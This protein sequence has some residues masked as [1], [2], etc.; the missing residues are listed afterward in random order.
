[1]KNLALLYIG[2]LTPD[3]AR[4]RTEATSTAAELF[5]RN[6]LKGLRASN[7]PEPEVL[8][9]VP[10]P[11]FPRQRLFVRA[12]ADRVEE[13]PACRTLGHV[14]LGPIKVLTLGVTAAWG[15]AKWA[16]K[17]RGRTKIAIV[18]N[19]NAPPAFA[20]IPVCRLF[21]IRLVPFVGDIYV[22][23][24]VVDDGL[25]RRLE[26]WL[27]RA[28]VPKADGLLICNQAI[29]DDFAPGRDALLVEGGVRRDFIERFSAPVRDSGGPFHVVFAG[30]LTELNGVT[31]LLDALAQLPDADLKVTIV[32]RGEHADAVRAVASQDPRIDYR[33]LVSHDEVMELYEQADLLLNLRR[34]GSQTERYVFPSKVVECLGTGRPLLTTATGH[35]R[36]EFGTFVYL[37]DDLTPEA[38]A[39]KLGEISTTPREDRLA[40]GRRAQAH[41][42]E[43]RTWEGHAQRVESYLRERV[44]KEAA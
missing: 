32:G 22:P 36:E 13:G 7:L 4:G 14:N 28:A 35:V 21:G 44:L 19:L 39:T 2:A 23:G 1:M 10:V 26:F 3:P 12:G 24:E 31:V 9:Y 41:V 43:T 34:T 8:A 5:Q 20:L 42:R 40:L 15:A 25:F 11:S 17:H 30:G 33:G 6:F 29:I 18:Y 38:L 16:I 27:Q 37:L